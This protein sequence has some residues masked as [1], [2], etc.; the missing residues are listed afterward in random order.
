MI[1]NNFNGAVSEMEDVEY[2]LLCIHGRESTRVAGV[3]SFARSFNDFLMGA[4][5]EI[6]GIVIFA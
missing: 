5:G 4:V 2:L 6:S 1:N 3:T